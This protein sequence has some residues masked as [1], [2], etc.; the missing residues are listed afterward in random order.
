[1]FGDLKVNVEWFGE[2]ETDGMYPSRSDYYLIDWDNGIEKGCFPAR[3]TIF[4]NNGSEIFIDYFQYFDWHDSSERMR[5]A[6]PDE[7]MGKLDD[8]C[9][10]WEG[11]ASEDAFTRNFEDRVMEI[12]KKEMGRYY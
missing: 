8:F 7:L 2:G 11:S 10:V 6:D 1:M 5:E 12:A 9:E 4:D 3:K